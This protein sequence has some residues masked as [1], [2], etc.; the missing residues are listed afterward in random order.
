MRF[1]F[2][3]TV[4]FLPQYIHDCQAVSERKKEKERER[5][6][7]GGGW[8]GEE[9][10]RGC[11]LLKEA[12]P[13]LSRHIQPPTPPSS[14]WDP[15]Q[16]L[17][18]LRRLFIYSCSPWKTFFLTLQIPP[19]PSSPVSPALTVW[20]RRLLENCCS[21]RSPPS[22]SGSV[23]IFSGTGLGVLICVCLISLSS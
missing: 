21:Q 12:C 15:Q 20:S 6:R 18:C 19:P 3:L 8:G 22:R 9:E 2:S 16:G 11:L 4:I 17:H 1:C 7:G 5:W 14:K 10:F 23:N 13:S